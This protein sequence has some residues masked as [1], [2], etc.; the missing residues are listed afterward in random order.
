M[1]L[2]ITP[3]QLDITPAAVDDLRARLARTR[4]PGQLDGGGWDYGTEEGYLQ[5]LCRHWAEAYDFADA[6]ARFNAYPQFMTEVGGEQ[7][8]FYHV[9]SPEPDAL[10]LIITHGWPGSVA[11]FLDVLGPLS[12]PAAHG[13]EPRQA[14]HVVAPSIPGYGPSGPTRQRSLTTAKI[15]AMFA[16]L[17]AALGYGRYVAQGGDWGAIISAHVAS[18]DAAH[19]AAL[20]LNL[21]YGRPPNS[22]DILAGLNETERQDVARTQAFNLEES[23]YQR[24]QETKPQTLAYGLTDSPAGLAG[25]I[26]EKFRTWSDCGGDPE[27]VYS[28]DRLLDN[29]TLYWLTG[30]INSSTRLYYENNGP[31]RAEP[32]ARDIKAPTGHALYPGEIVRTPR[33]WAEQV[34]N[35]IQSWTTM[36]RGGHFA[37]MEQPA[38][39]TEELR[40][41]FADYRGA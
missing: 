35:N 9:R 6:A 30:T 41:F 22:K 10:P 7:L 25:W 2:T 19:V 20:H 17:M 24:I 38:L 15:A 21:I 29:I 34:F 28:R 31:G 23:G 27:S 1:T 13:G 40:R 12:D 32:F 16:E 33:P 4:W 11:E 5:G 39:F 37:A 3:Y 36:P 26:V 18:V 8:H 14:F